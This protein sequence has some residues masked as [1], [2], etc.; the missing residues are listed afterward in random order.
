[1]K[2]WELRFHKSYYIV[3]LQDSLAMCVRFD[4][5]LVSFPSFVSVLCFFVVALALHFLVHAK[6]AKRFSTLV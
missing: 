4:L 5:S 2:E 6:A 3:M 1:M